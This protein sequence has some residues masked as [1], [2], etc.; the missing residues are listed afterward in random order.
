[1]AT[2]HLADAVFDVCPSRGATLDL[3]DR[4]SRSLQA[5]TA[6]FLFL[7]VIAQPLSIAAS[8]VAYAGAAFAWV[9]RLALVRRGM[10]KSSPLDLPILIYLLLCTVATLLSPMPA[11]SWEGMRKVALV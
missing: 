5:I 11:S 3:P 7:F 4:L 2:N 1:M 10:L 9:L 6:F 8:H